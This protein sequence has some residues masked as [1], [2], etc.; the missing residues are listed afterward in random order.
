MRLINT[1]NVEKYVVCGLSMSQAMHS[2]E[3]I[4]RRDGYVTL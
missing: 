1:A 3:E 4:E 2:H